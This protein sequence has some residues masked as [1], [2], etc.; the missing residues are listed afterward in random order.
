MTWITAPL[1]KVAP[2]VPAQTGFAPNDHVWQ[3]SLDQIESG[4]GVIIGKRYA[5]ASDAG[6]EPVRISVWN[7]VM[8]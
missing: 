6:T 5:A 7:G 1:R 8:K 3:L 4:T 2:A